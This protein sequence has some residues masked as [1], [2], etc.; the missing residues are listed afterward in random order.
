MDDYQTPNEVALRLRKHPET[1]TRALR[2]R[3]LHGYQSGNKRKGRWLVEPTCADA[4]VRGQKCEH[5]LAE[6]AAA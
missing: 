4:W 1:I 2:L 5:Q 3:E 6:A